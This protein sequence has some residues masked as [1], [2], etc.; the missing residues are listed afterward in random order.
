MN[1]PVSIKSYSQA[2]YQWGRKIKW[3]TLERL[4]ES[5]M[6]KNEETMEG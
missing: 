4:Q 5:H 2:Q 3:L 1:S 6:T